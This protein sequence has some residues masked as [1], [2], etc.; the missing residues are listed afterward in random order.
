[1]AFNLTNMNNIPIEVIL[2]IFCMLI[3]AKDIIKFSNSNDY[4]FN[5]Y[6]NNLDKIVN[7]LII[8]NQTNGVVNYVITG[9]YNKTDSIDKKLNYIKLIADFLSKTT[10]EELNYQYETMNR[11]NNFL[12]HHYEN[13]RIDINTRMIKYYYFRVVGNFP[14]KLAKEASRLS[15]EDYL[16]FMNLIRLG[17]DITTSYYATT[18]LDNEKI[19]LMH[20]VAKRGIKL[21][22]AFHVARD[23]SQDKIEKFF[24]FIGKNIEA[25]NAILIINDFN[26]VQINKLE[27]VIQNGIDPNDAVFMVDKFDDNRIELIIQVTSINNSPKLLNDIIE[28]ERDADE[29]SIMIKLL[30]NNFDIEEIGSIA[31]N[32]S[33]MVDF[34]DDYII[35][36]IELKSKGISESNILQ[37]LESAMF[38]NFDFEYYDVLIKKIN[39]IETVI[40]IICDETNDEDIN[41][42]IEL[43]NEGICKEYVF[44]LTKTYSKEEAL[45]LK[46]YLEYINCTNDIE[47]FMI[48]YDEIKDYIKMFQDN[49]LND[50]HIANYLISN[51][52]MFPKFNVPFV[53]KLIRV[54]KKLQQYQLDDDFI[55]DFIS[56]YTSQCRHIEH[57]YRFNLDEPASKRPIINMETIYDLPQFNA[58]I[59]L[60]NKGF[61]DNYKLVH[62]INIMF[63][64]D[65]DTT[66]YINNLNEAD[67]DFIKTFNEI[68]LTIFLNLCKETNNVDNTML[69]MKKLNEDS[70][71]IIYNFASNTGNSYKSSLKNFLEQA[72]NNMPNKN[73]KN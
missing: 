12:L 55:I 4:V 14:H 70:I 67:I 33:G 9:G 45:L 40:E 7:K 24:E 11:D 58:C 73:Y 47:N 44:Y 68:K 60:I 8:N 38:E 15:S 41:K 72:R 32:L 50:K 53:S 65:I 48:N 30:E 31:F 54:I 62:F 2:N 25:C 35:K 5:I 57:N 27:E 51:Q 61:R 13:Y 26:E 66:K 49:N 42:I 37:L 69:L 16:R 17:Y 3:D 22:D 59:R 1:M 6:K 23:I 10:K 19:N 52:F 64:H 18:G 29:L 56:H 39:D 28:V 46:P 36:C 71:T 43:I 63:K 21:N 34:N 20:Q